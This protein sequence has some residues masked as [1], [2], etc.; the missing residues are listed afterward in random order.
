MTFGW[1]DCSACG[2]LQPCKANK[3]K[4]PTK[5][6]IEFSFF[7][8]SFTHQ[9][10]QE[11]I[12]GIVQ[13][14]INLRTVRNT[15]HR[16]HQDEVAVGTH[17][18]TVGRRS[19]AFHNPVGGFLVSL[20]RQISTQLVKGG[21]RAGSCRSIARFIRDIGSIEIPVGNQV[22]RKILVVEDKVV[23]LFSLFQIFRY[24]LSSQPSADIQC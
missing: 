1:T 18:G 20:I 12:V 16:V 14:Y 9:S 17:L 13:R 15:A 23:D 22:F 3:P 10:F 19:E 8:V 21:R 7:Q 5:Y 4:P 6:L 24:V 2:A 11:V